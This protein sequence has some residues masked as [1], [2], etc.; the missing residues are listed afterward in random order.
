LAIKQVLGFTVGYYGSV[1]QVTGNSTYARELAVNYLQSGLNNIGNMHPDWGTS[2]NIT[3]IDMHTFWFANASYSRGQV[4]VNYSLTGL[5]MY[6]ITYA[7]SSKLTVNILSSPSSNQTSVSITIDEDEPL[8]NLGKSNFKFYRYLYD[9]ST[10]DLVSPVLEPMAFANGTYILDN[11]AG[12]DP[13]SYLIQVEDARGI[14]VVASSFTR[15]TCS[16]FWNPVATAGYAVAGSVPAILGPPDMN[17]AT[18]TNGATCETLDYYGG[19]QTISQVYFNISYYGAISGTLEWYYRLDGGSWNKIENLPQ[20]G[21][22]ASPLTR[23]FNATG[24]RASWTWSN[25]NSTDIRFFNN[26]GGSAEDAYV[27][28]MYVTIVPQRVGDYSTIPNSTIV[29]ELLQNGTMRW[30]G[31]SL[32]LTTPNKPV[33]PVPV[34]AIHVNQTIN[35]ANVEVPFQV[36]D[37][38]SQY[39]VPL[40]MTNNASVFGSK[41]MIVFLATANTSKVTIWWD[42]ND[43]ANQTSYAFVNRYF[44]GDN[45]S[46]SILT[47]GQL[48]LQF[49]GGF[50]VTATVG[51][52][53][54]TATFMRIDTEAST[55]G[56]DLSYVITRGVVRDIVHQEAEWGTGSGGGGAKDCPNIYCHIVLTLPAN[57]T[58]YTYK[59]RLMFVDSQQTRNI[60][61]LSAISLTTTIN[62]GQTENGTSNGYPVISDVSGIFSNFSAPFT[63]HH[64]AQLISG[65]TGTGIM[66]TDAANRE[67]YA[68]DGIAG[69]A[70]GGLKTDLSNRKIE[71]LPITLAPV[72]F[73]Y[74][75]DKT[76]DGAVVTFDSTTPIYKD[77]SGTKT[78]LWILVECPPTI[79][80]RA[81]S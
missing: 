16:M 58:Y 33:P 17:Y 31:Q 12:V 79:E 27:D 19:T 66:F 50:T 40:G 42:G 39:Q 41:N 4:C 71:L 38:G 6:G 10:W 3:N 37:W 2:F 34:R 5:G 49:G 65:T 69:R 22:S 26:D 64:W 8:I 30:L 75:L 45:P 36:E 23:S 52:R 44:T 56:S 76:W 46:A 60:T 57:S 72:Q 25:V 21:T 24:L 55:Y 29:V 18:V 28:S 53:T 43:N 67:L 77:Q 80:I 51:T 48:R 35:G 74:A 81:E 68:F 1:L 63:A 15:Y 13:Y 59:I 47:N 20:G 70:T 54:S 61:D 11:P 7:T 14:I 73:T 78:G 62:S 32:E 9:N